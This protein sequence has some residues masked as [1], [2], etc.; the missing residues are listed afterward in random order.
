MSSQTAKTPKLDNIIGISSLIRG[1]LGVEPF[2][3]PVNTHDLLLSVQLVQKFKITIT[4]D[5]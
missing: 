4:F 2:V 3:L 5:L 1:I